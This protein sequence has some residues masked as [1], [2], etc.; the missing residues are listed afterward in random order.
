MESQFCMF[1]LMPVSHCLDYYG[2]VLKLGSVNTP[3]LPL[4]FRIGLAIPDPYVFSE[5]ASQ[6]LKKLQCG[7]L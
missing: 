7:Y 3:P 6:L 4:L 2:L 1:I 5:S